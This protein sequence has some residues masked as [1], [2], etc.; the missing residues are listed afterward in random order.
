[1]SGAF[2]LGTYTL[3]QRELVRFFR[4]RNR[5]SGALLQP[6]IFWVLF[7]AGLNASFRPA[8]GGDDYMVYFFPGILVMILL[9]TAIFATVSVI[10]DRREGF[11]QSVLVAPVPRGA[12]VLGKL[13]GGTALAV[14][15]GLVFMLLGLTQGIGYSAATFGAVLGAM[16][17][18]AFALTGLGFIFAWR[19]EST[20]GFHA[21]ITV[22]LL[23]MWLLSGAFFPAD[24]THPVLY[25]V[26]QLNPLTYGTALMRHAMY[27]DPART[28]APG[29]P[30][31]ALAL[32]VS[33]GFA[34]LTFAL[35]YRIAGTR[36]AGDLQ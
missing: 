31:P 3:A 6:I 32:G 7:G 11:L 23:P 21:I 10:E 9:F 25:A 13:L 27:L 28:A 19:M 36:V 24:G 14:L 12:M 30:G 33:A 5:V 20:Q 35:S 1:M 17:L 26:M 16:L 4:Q 18:L 29:V 15:Q 2:V 22:L 8:R 34:L